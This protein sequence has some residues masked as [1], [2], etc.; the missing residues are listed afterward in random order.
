MGEPSELEHA[1]AARIVHDELTRRLGRPAPFVVPAGGPP[2]TALAPRSFPAAVL[3][4]RR[5]VLD[6]L[7][8]LDRPELP[9]TATLEDRVAVAGPP[10]GTDVDAGA[11]AWWD[12]VFDAAADG[13]DPGWRSRPRTGT[14]SFARLEALTLGTDA[15]FGRRRRADPWSALREAARWAGATKRR[16]V[17]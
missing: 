7:G 14:G 2:L 1:V 6:A 17:G 4:R 16:L 15:F 11:A 5:R 13:I 9:V 12:A 3:E 10:L 8:W